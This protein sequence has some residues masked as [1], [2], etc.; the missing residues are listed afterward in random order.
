MRGAVLVGVLSLVPAAAAQGQFVACNGENRQ[1]IVSEPSATAGVVILHWEILG[2]GNCMPPNEVP[3]WVVQRCHE[4]TCTDYPFHV[5]GTDP[6]RIWIRPDNLGLY[7]VYAFFRQ[8][9]HFDAVGYVRRGPVPDEDCVL[10]PEKS[11][12]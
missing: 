5:Y 9:S 8:F 6:Y 4:G 11:G 1:A 7:T 3:Y 12:C 10:Y 2:L